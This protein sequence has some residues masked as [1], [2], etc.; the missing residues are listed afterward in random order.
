MAS[1]LLA[2]GDTALADVLLRLAAAADVETTVAGD[3]AQVRAAW[4]DTDLACVGDDLAEDLARSEPP[5]RSGVVLVATHED[6]GAYRRAVAV[7]AQDVA[8]LPD[9]EQWLIDRMAA[10]A[11][12]DGT[13]AVTVG[14]V[15]GRGGAGAS[16]LAASLAV[17]G[18]RGGLRT[19]LVDA[20][21]LGGGIDLVLGEETASGARWPE[22]AARQGRLS[23]AALRAAVPSVDTLAVLACGRGDTAPIPPAAMRAVLPAAGQGD[24]VV[25][26]LPRHVDAAATEALIAA[27]VVLAVVPAEVRATVA[28]HGVIADM[29]RHVD[30]VRVVVRGPAPGGLRPETIAESLGSTLAGWVPYDRR[31]AIGLEAAEPSFIA[32][33]GPVTDFCVEFLTDL[34]LLPVEAAA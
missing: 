15:G 19:F 21:P 4:T 32:G 16:V 29:R 30:D 33:R 14:V 22:L 31:L 25:V 10:A 20:D 3:V 28:A 27:D 11:E 5:R 23:G 6:T 7:G 18:R 8:V 1:V 24:L 34:S 26:D 13:A 2:T 12:P 9:G 17:T